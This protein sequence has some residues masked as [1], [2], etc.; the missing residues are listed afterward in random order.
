MRCDTCKK[1]F[2]MR[3]LTPPL[4]SKPAKGYSWTCA[5]CSRRHEQAVERSTAGAGGSLGLTVPSSSS[6]SSSASGSV[7]IARLPGTQGAIR[8]GTIS[9][10]R[11]R[12]R[13][14][15][16][17]GEAARDYLASFPY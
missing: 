8:G 1:F 15:G 9:R 2:H 13:G 12:G 14:R 17:A 7:E 3:C 10:G 6:S 11:G 16:G 4:A 5:P